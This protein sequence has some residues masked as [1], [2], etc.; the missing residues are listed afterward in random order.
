MGRTRVLV[1]GRPR[2]VQ[3]NLWRCLALI[4]LLRLGP[5]RGDG[6][7]LGGRRAVGLRRE[8]PHEHPRM[9]GVPVLAGVIAPVVLRVGVTLTVLVVPAV[10]VVVVARVLVARVPV[11]TLVMVIAG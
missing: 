2:S 5:H 11:V 4:I 6:V 10:P 3:L 1:D 9:I 7:G 8:S